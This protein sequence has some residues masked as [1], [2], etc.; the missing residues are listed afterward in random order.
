MLRALIVEEMQAPRFRA[1]LQLAAELA[2]DE[3]ERIVARELPAFTV[4]GGFRG[5]EVAAFVGF[6]KSKDVVV[7]EY[8]AV[9]EA[10]QRT[11]LGSALVEAASRAAQ[12]KP[13]VAE[14]DDD[15]VDFY[16]ALGFSVVAIGP[17]PHWPGRARYRC[18]RSA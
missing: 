8:I 9:D 15:A 2:A 18:I 17:D 7:I 3:L 12:N 5:H 6:R 10:A 13:V 1:L 4:Y 16:R 11:G 14:T